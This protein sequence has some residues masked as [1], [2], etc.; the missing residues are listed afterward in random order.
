MIRTRSRIS[1][2]AAFSF[3]TAGCASI[4]GQTN[5]PVVINSTPDDAAIV[6]KDERGLAVF[7][8][9]TPTTVSLL[10]GE[11][12]FH[13]KSYT[14]E[15]SK[16]GYET[17]TAYIKSSISGWYFGNILIGGVVGFL[18]V[19]PITGKMYKLPKDVQIVLPEGKSAANLSQPTLQIVSI[20]DI[21]PDLRKQLVRIR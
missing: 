8:G 19:D 16:P 9:K 10:S 21:D 3:L 1:I 12:Y 5:Y 13:G 20:N 18:I 2:I 14:V 15:F 6:V 17:Q 11:S 7:K 4:V